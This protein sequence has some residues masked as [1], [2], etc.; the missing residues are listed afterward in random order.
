MAEVV[1]VDIVVVAAE[2]VDEGQQQLS[3][4]SPEKAMHS[5]TQF[6]RTGWLAS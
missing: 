5:F 3:Q 1:V 2:L 4:L 6:G